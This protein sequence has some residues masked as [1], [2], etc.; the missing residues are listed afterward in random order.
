MYREYRINLLVMIHNG[1]QNIKWN[2]LIILYFFLNLIL[3]PFT[4]IRM[5]YYMVY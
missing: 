2:Q 3:G 4:L 5:L 1:Y